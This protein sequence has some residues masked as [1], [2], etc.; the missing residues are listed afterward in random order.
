MTTPEGKVKDGVKKVLT[1]RGWWYYM[2]V[3]G[4]YSTHGIPDFM[5]CKDGQLL[6]VETKAPGKLNNTTPNQKRVLAELTAA[7]AWVVVVD[8]P[9]QLEDFLT[10][11]EKAHAQINP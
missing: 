3:A 1:A 5:C 6:G 10:E 8:D 2:A 7:G 9:K 11:K 4:P